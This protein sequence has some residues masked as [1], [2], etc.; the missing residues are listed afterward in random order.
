VINAGRGSRVLIYFSNAERRSGSGDPNKAEQLRKA[1]AAKR[2]GSVC[3]AVGW[4]YVRPPDKKLKCLERIDLFYQNL[5]F[6]FRFRL[7][8]GACIV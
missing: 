2:C 6:Y 7:G 1:A 5:F 3:G 8:G 4:C